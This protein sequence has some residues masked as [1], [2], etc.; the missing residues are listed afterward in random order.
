[1]KIIS[2]L[3]Y[4]ILFGSFNLSAQPGQL[5]S[6]FD[7]DGKL[8]TIIENEFWTYGTS[9]AVQPDNKIVAG[10]IDGT[11]LLIRYN[12]DGSIDS[13]FGEIFTAIPGGYELGTGVLLQPDGKILQSGL[14]YYGF[15]L[16]RYNSDGSIDNS[17]GDEGI[18]ITSF[19]DYHTGGSLLQLQPD[20]KILQAGYTDFFGD[21]NFGL[22]R[23]NSDGTLDNSFGIDGKVETDFDGHIDQPTSMRL[24]QDGKIVVAGFSQS[25]EYRFELVRYNSDG[26]LDPGFGMGGKLVTKIGTFS[27]L[28]DMIVQADGKI[29]IAGT[30]YDT[31]FYNTHV[32]K[33][34][35]YN[36][37]G[38]ID[39][40]FGTNG[41]VSSSN[42][43]GLAGNFDLTFQP[44]G[45]I[46]LVGRGD[47]DNLYDIG[48]FGVERYYA[49][50][51]L[52]STFGNSGLALADLSYGEADNVP[53]DVAIDQNGRIVVIG[54]TEYTPTKYCVALA[55][56][57]SGLNV[58]ILDLSTSNSPI[59]IYPNPI[60]KQAVLEY[61]L[62]G[63]ETISIALLDI[64]GRVV[65]IFMQSQQRMKGKQ[66][67][68]LAFEKS[69]PAG[70]YI[71]S[72]SNEVHQQNIKIVKKD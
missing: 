3:F 52:D 42:Y 48:K 63:A 47:Y 1:M 71:L 28:H 5:D 41:I 65:Q 13:D 29:L 43:D 21:T 10:G 15:A 20:G 72:I 8:T 39:N 59:F 30:V 55:R 45:K 17:F 56:F 44:D 27:E 32:F 6:T 53:T 18:A 58:G 26:S 46:I 22:I 36:S 37:D 7:G 50:G 49:D 69:I 19:D 68:V 61:T 35:R 33:M 40:S 16:V 4:C 57:L 51:L 67:E 31:I 60:Q 64:Q 11:F 54:Y 12:Y 24:Q 62:N 25:T 34:L 2:G 23:Y 70:E 66:K 9:I 38:T 14:C